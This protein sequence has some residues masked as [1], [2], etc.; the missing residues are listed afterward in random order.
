MTGD[1]LFTDGVDWGDVGVMGFKVLLEFV[2]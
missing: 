2:F 1:P